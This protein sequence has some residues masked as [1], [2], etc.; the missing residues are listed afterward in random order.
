MLKVGETAPDF[1]A[2]TTAGRDLRLSDLR[3]QP[4]VL[5]F[6]PRAFTYT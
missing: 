4:I 6:F 1:S 5:Y 3:G 2:K